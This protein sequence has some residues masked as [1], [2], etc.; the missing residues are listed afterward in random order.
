MNTQYRTTNLL[1]AVLFF[2]ILFMTAGRSA[3]AACAGPVSTNAG[4]DLCAVGHGRPEQKNETGRMDICVSC[5]WDDEE[6]R[7]GIRPES[8]T[9]TLYANGMETGRSI[10]LCEENG[11]SGC[12]EN[13]DACRNGEML[14]YSVI[15]ERVEGYTGTIAGTDIEGYRVINIHEPLPEGRSGQNVITPDLRVSGRKGVV[16]E[17][18]VTT[19]VSRSVPARTST[20]TKRSRSAKTADTSRP[21]LWEI[22]ILISCAGLYVWMRAEQ[23]KG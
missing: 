23:N 6:N 16:V 21:A 9:V 17:T 3:Q 7:D 13:M 18:V 10:T 22:L 11:W 5:E 12:F 8:V 4:T 1:K 15:E 19:K 20:T 2:F 14:S